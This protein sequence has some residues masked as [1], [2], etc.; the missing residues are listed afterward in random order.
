MY[1]VVFKSGGVTSWSLK[2]MI[3]PTVLEE[4]L[5]NH[6]VYIVEDSAKQSKHTDYQNIVKEYNGRLLICGISNE[7]NSGDLITVDGEKCLVLEVNPDDEEMICMMSDGKISQV[8]VGPEIAFVES[9][10]ISEH[11]SQL[12]DIIKNI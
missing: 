2:D 5:C 3:D 7:L 12:H 11:L 6:D 4:L 10:D 1:L 9:T 8:C